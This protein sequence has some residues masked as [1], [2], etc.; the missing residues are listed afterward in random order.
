MPLTQSS[1]KKHTNYFVEIAHEIGINFKLT[2]LLK[3]E[4]I[5]VKYS[6]PTWLKLKSEL[7]V[8]HDALSKASK[9]YLEFN[10]QSN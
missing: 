7:E 3:V 9:P 4:F 10:V 1:H 6:V 5:Y 2:S 8:S